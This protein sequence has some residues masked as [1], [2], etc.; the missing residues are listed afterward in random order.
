MKRVLSK[1]PAIVSNV[2]VL[3]FSLFSWIL[4][5]SPSVEYAFGFMRNMVVGNPACNYKDFAKAL[6][7]VDYSGL[8]LLIAGFIL[9]YPTPCAALCKIDKR[10][11]GSLFTIVAIL[12]YVFAMTG[13]VTPGIYENF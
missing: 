11:H 9:S 10:L 5:R 7:F 2:Y 6:Y 8:F 1:A 12:A 13:S 4:F 3:A